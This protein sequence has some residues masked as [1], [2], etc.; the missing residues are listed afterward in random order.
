MILLKLLKQAIS[1]YIVLVSLFFSFSTGNTNTC[2]GDNV[3][4]LKTDCTIITKKPLIIDKQVT[5]RK[6]ESKL[7]HIEKIEAGLVIVGTSISNISFPSIKEIRNNA[8]P[9]I[10]FDGNSHLGHFHTPNLEQLSGKPNALHFRNDQFIKSVLNGK[11]E[12]SFM[13]FQFMRNKSNYTSCDDNFYTV[14]DSDDVTDS[15]R[16]FFD[17]LFVTIVLLVLLALII[18]CLILFCFCVSKQRKLRLRMRWFKRKQMKK[19]ESSEETK[20]NSSKP[21]NKIGK[22]SEAEIY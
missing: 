15:E 3:K 8:G 20:S 14:K 7:K 11:D 22:R 13:D 17:K 19:E 21:L 12:K 5:E 1:I 9:A 18:S 4:D 16:G 2:E 6:L 10:Y